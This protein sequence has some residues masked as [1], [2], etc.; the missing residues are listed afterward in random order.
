M[1]QIEEE[2][3]II[4]WVIACHNKKF[5]TKHLAEEEIKCLKESDKK[6]NVRKHYRIIKAKYTE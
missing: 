3:A 4:G 5:E 1:Y 2:N 6:R